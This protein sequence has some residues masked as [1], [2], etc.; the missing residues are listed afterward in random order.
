MK[1]RLS[2][3]GTSE[4]S[5]AESGRT[6]TEHEGRPTGG[7]AASGAVLSAGL[8][9][10]RV[11]PAVGA[12][13]LHLEP[14]GVVAPVLLGDVVA[15]LALLAGQRDLGADIGGGHG[16]VPLPAKRRKR[17]RRSLSDV[18]VAGFEPATQR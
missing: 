12:E 4:S 10:R 9:V 16:G 3:T 15:V 17:E 8:A 2:G 7:G 13:L 11:V 14:V 1:S 6:L 5:Y 18:A